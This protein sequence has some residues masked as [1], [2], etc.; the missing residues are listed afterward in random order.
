MLTTWLPRSWHN[1]LILL[2]LPFSAFLLPVFLLAWSQAEAAP[3]ERAVSL[4]LIWHLL[5][6]PASNGYN[7]WIDRDTEAIGGLAAPP[8][9]P[10]QLPWVCGLLD[11]V[12]VGWAFFLGREVGL[13]VLGFILASRA[14]SAPGPVSNA[15]PG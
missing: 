12:A 5:V 11:L 3:P 4:A 14:Y 9:P 1:T 6:Y 7:S 13:G 8:P 10:A 15:I 2:R